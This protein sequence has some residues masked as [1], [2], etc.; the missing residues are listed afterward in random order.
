MPPDCELAFEQ[1]TEQCKVG[2]HF[3]QATYERGI[4]HLGERLR[5]LSNTDPES[6]LRFIDQIITTWRNDPQVAMRTELVEELQG[7][8]KTIEENEKLKELKTL[9][10][11]AMLQ[12]QWVEAERYSDETL[13]IPGFYTDANRAE[14]LLYYDARIAKGGG[15]GG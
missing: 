2:T 12:G 10:D 3:K 1:Y 9:Y 5:S 11:Q 6:A 7:V 8:R 4:D 14:V 15:N 13:K